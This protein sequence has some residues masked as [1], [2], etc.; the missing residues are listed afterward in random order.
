M[1]S[2]RPGRQDPIKQEAS[3]ELRNRSRREAQ[4]S[5]CLS[6]KVKNVADQFK[7][8]VPARQTPVAVPPERPTLERY[9][10]G[11]QSSDRKQAADQAKSRAS[12]IPPSN[13]FSSSPLLAAAPSQASTG[14]RNLRKESN[15]HKVGRFFC[16]PR[17]DPKYDPP[18][19][20]QIL[21]AQCLLRA[22]M[23]ES[24]SLS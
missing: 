21:T 20:G 19:N 6:G 13:T 24:M 3:A 15:I 10:S 7:S 12:A 1:S 5:G 23:E 2:G 17:F 4:A 18:P 8:C 11:I 14:A 22:G 16:G 9:P